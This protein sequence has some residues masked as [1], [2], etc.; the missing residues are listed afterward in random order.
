MTTKTMTTIEIEFGAH[1]PAP[2]RVWSEKINA[3]FNDLS[4]VGRN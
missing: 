3:N 1:G 2:R 4:A